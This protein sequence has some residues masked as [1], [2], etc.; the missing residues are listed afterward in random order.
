[1]YSEWLDLLEKA[2]KTSIISSRCRKIHYKFPDNSEMVE[3]YNADTGVILRRAWKRKA[4][5]QKDCES[6]EV[7]LGDSVPDIIRSDGELLLKESNSEVIYLV[8]GAE[9]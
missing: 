7:E 3:E 8:N 1:M 4:F 2:D 5:L 9:R 6:W